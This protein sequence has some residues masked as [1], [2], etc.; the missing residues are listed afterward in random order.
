MLCC[1]W[2]GERIREGRRKVGGD[3]SVLLDC[4]SRRTAGRKTV[5]VDIVGG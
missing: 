5:G 3:C 1:C 4:R 2:I